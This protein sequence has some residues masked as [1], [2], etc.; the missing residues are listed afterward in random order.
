M[1]ALADRVTTIEQAPDTT[2]GLADD[3][4]TLKNRVSGNDSDISFLFN[5]TGS[6]DSNGTY[7]GKVGPGQVV[8]GDN[9][10]CTNGQPRAAMWNSNQLW[11]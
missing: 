8:L 1:S 5:K 9:H 2:T 4:N 10:A 7:H 3:V 11:C 6:L